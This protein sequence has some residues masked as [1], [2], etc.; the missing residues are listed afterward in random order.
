MVSAS[1][2][3]P[4]WFVYVFA[5]LLHR[6]EDHCGRPDPI[7]EEALRCDDPDRLLSERLCLD[8][9][10]AVHGQP[11]PQVCDLADQHHREHPAQRRQAL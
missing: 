10:P 1:P 8:R 7:C 6:P 11:A 2:V 5:W 3:S 4:A 9:S